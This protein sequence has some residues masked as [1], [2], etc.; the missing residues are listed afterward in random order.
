MKPGDYVRTCQ[1]CGNVQ[2]A[3]NP[4]EYKNDNWRDLLCKKCKSA[5]LDY[6]KT[7]Q[8]HEVIDYELD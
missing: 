5:A 2:I 8:A 1:E 4:K 6:G 3:R 7:Y